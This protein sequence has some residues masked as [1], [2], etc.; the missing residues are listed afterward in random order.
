MRMCVFGFFYICMVHMH[1]YHDFL[2]SMFGG[3]ISR[4]LRCECEGNRSSFAVRVVSTQGL[5]WSLGTSS[6]LVGTALLRLLPVGASSV[7]LAHLSVCLSISLNFCMLYVECFHPIFPSSLSLEH[8]GRCPSLVAQ[9]RK[10]TRSVFT[11]PQSLHASSLAET[12]RLPPGAGLDNS[13]KS[14]LLHRL[15][16][17]QV[18]ALQPTERPHID[19]FQLGGVSFKVRF[20][21]HTHL[22]L[23]CTVVVLPLNRNRTRLFL[24]PISRGRRA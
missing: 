2:S 12:N 13:G 7:L 4:V 6:G 22:V 19:E 3:S 10:A 11:W 15:S 17:G 8:V 9:A 24:P 18:T 1:M 16:Q 20:V 23:R 21:R 5:I 14:T